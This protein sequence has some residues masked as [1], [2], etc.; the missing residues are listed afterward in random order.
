MSTETSIDEPTYEDLASGNLGHIEV[1]E[2]QFNSNK[3]TYAE[4]VHF[5]FSI[6]DPTMFGLQGDDIGQQYS[7]VIFTH[8]EAQAKVAREVK[9]KVEQLVASRRL[10]C[11]SGD[12]VTT[13]IYPATQFYFAKLED[14]KYFVS[15]PGFKCWHRQFFRWSDFEALAPEPEKPPNEEAMLKP[16]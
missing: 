4:L 8:S 9:H 6:H 14:Q 2:I 1:V 5:F 7:S 12:S 11:F 10:P 16:N 13:E 3:V 15:Q